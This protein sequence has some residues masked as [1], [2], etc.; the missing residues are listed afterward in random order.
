LTW[1]R[2]HGYR[3]LIAVDPNASVCPY[4]RSLSEEDLRGEHGQPAE[5]WAPY[6]LDWYRFLD[7]VS[8]RQGSKRVGTLIVVRL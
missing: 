2:A 6:Y 3:Y 1:L 7:A 4:K 8:S 5:A